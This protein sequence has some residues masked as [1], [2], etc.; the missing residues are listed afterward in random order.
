MKIK[1]PKSEKTIKKEERK[2][3]A[4]SA[5]SKDKIT[6]EELRDLIIDLIEMFEELNQ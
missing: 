5:K 2:A 3:R 4:E 6:N 1:I